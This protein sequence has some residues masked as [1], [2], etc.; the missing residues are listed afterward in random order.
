[1]LALP[2][3]SDQL[4]SYTAMLVRREAIIARRIPAEKKSLTLPPGARFRLPPWDEM[5]SSSAKWPHA[6]G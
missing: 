1:M 5:V 3:A 4:N 6:A 2:E